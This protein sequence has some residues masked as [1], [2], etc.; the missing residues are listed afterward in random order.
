MVEDRF[1]VGEQRVL[2]EGG[3]GFFD[4]VA[5][6][7]GAAFLGSDAGLGVAFAEEEI[8]FGEVVHGGVR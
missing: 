7:D 1:V 3:E 2:G 6:V 4:V 5:E 8:V